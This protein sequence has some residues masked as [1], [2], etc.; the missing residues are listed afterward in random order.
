[1][2][3]NVELLLN[4]AADGDD[5]EEEDDND[6]ANANNSDFRIT[7]FYSL[8]Q[9]YKCAVSRTDHASKKNIRKK[10]KVRKKGGSRVEEEDFANR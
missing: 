6:D 7:F 9:K 3:T 1:M 8:T 5:D 10:G 4:T 2:K